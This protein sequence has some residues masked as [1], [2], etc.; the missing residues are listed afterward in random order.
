MVFM[1]ILYN[2]NDIAWHIR[3]A[4]DILYVNNTLNKCPPK[5]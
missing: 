5:L 3:K 2:E 1:N 4:C